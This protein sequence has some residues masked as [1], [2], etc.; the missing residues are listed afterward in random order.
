MNE[1]ERDGSGLLGGPL[2]LVGLWLWASGVTHL[3]VLM[4]EAVNE[5]TSISHEGVAEVLL[6]GCQVPSPRNPPIG[7]HNTLYGLALDTE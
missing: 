2:T 1:G 6:P 4:A 3:R 5:R 7:D